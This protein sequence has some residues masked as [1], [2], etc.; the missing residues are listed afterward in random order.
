M[1]HLF[2]PSSG[3]YQITLWR[4]L[5][6]LYEG[7]EYHD[8]LTDGEAI[9][10]S[11]DA[12]TATGPYLKKPAAHGSRV[13][14]GQVWPKLHQQFNETRIVGQ[15]TIRPTFYLSFDPCIEVFDGVCHETKLAYLITN[16]NCGERLRLENGSLW[17]Y[18]PTA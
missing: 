12:F 8:P 6:L 5:G 15:N 18:R 4:F 13:R 14:H 1:E 3:D 7:V 17:P 9:K 10:R 16:F 2:H 11:T